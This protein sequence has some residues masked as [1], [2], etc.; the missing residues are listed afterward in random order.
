MRTSK[1]ILSASMSLLLCAAA[2]SATDK[3]DT[4]K[5]GVYEY[6]VR[7]SQMEFA[8]A[9][10]LL[11]QQFHDSDFQLLAKLDAGVPKG[12]PYRARVFVVFD[13]EYGQKLLEANRLTAA[14]ALLDR[15]NLFEDEAGL[16]VAIVNPLNVNR[17][18]L[19]DDFSYNDLALNHKAKLRK[20]ILAAEI[21]PESQTQFGKFRKKGYIGKTFGIMAGGPF[22]KK[23]KEVATLSD[24]D[25]SEV[26][27]KV[28]E[29]LSQGE[30]KWGMRLA[31][32]LVLNDAGIAILE[33][34]SPKIEKKSFKIV[35]AGSDKSRKH[36]AFPGLAH[37][38][39]YP[40]EVV[41]AREEDGVKVRLVN[42]MYRMKM[43]FEDAGKMA[44]AKNMG[45]PGSI[46]DEIQKQVSL[47]LGLKP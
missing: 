6:V 43:Y 8:S 11:E 1:I 37:A 23:I 15:I 19:M 7:G 30:G 46:Q 27:E 36:L 2:R 47:A 16:H 10:S 12:C 41:V 44:F 28:K 26:V 9:S 40:I 32:T 29:G 14:F 34:T 13:P 25:F 21:G 4:A 22:N 24:A 33:T 35:K 38:A 3:L 42:I 20:L 18:V 5:Q 17:T 39:G 31:C 45:M